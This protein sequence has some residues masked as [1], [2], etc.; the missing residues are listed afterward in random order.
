M[1]HDSDERASGGTVSTSSS[2]GA[3]R[4]QAAL[5]DGLRTV[6]VRGCRPDTGGAAGQDAGQEYHSVSHTVGSVPKSAT[7]CK[8]SKKSDGAGG[9]PGATGDQ[10]E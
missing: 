5:G 10:Y 8:K 2:Q 4:G 9:A 1:P 3:G 7:Q 6:L